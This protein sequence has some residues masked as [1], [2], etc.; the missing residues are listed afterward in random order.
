MGAIR[1]MKKTDAIRRRVWQLA[2]MVTVSFDNDILGVGQSTT[3]R[4]ILAGTL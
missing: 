1:S 4:L 3:V 2:E